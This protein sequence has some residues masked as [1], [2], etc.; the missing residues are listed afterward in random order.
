M[1]Q[2]AIKRNSKNYKVSNNIEVT[3]AIKKP[4]K[5]STPV[6]RNINQV[7]SKSALCQ[8]FVATNMNTMAESSSFMKLDFS[9]PVT[10]RQIP[11]ILEF[12]DILINNRSRRGIIKNDECLSPVYDES[13]ISHALK[14]QRAYRWNKIKASVGLKGNCQKLSSKAISSELNNYLIT[15]IMKNEKMCSCVQSLN[16]GISSFVDSYKDSFEWN[17]KLSSNNVF[18]IIKEFNIRRLRY[19]RILV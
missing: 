16:V 4:S 18:L 5:I 1:V 19:G 2:N 8:S 3:R 12:V 14:I 6:S 10:K 9:N 13:K 17:S 7:K 11:M 15:K